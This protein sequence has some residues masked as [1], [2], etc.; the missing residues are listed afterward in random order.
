[1]TPF[2][3]IAPPTGKKVILIQKV[4]LLVLYIIRKWW[5]FG[6]KS[7]TVHSIAF[8]NGQLSIGVVVKRTKKP[9]EVHCYFS[10]MRGVSITTTN[11]RAC[12]WKLPNNSITCAVHYSTMIFMYIYFTTC[13]LQLDWTLSSPPKKNIDTRIQQ[14]GSNNNKE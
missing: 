1:M 11:L 10:Y 2:G 3:K 13:W 6:Y 7:F 14:A 5:T 4:I 8:F 9:Q 12:Q